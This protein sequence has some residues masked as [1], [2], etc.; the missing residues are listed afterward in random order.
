MRL[1]NP[2]AP[3]F[4]CRV[5]Y[6]GDAGAQRGWYEAVPSTHPALAEAALHLRAAG[7]LYMLHR[8]RRRNASRRGTVGPELTGFYAHALRMFRETFG[9]I[10]KKVLRFLA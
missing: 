7:G 9:P 1:R 5:S 4:T 6:Y 8:W 2:S 10:S 3:S